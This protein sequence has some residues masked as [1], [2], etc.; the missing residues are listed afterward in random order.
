MRPRMNKYTTEVHKYARRLY[1]LA[2]EMSRNL[3]AGLYGPKAT[4]EEIL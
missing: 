2:P 4:G 3:F 1:G